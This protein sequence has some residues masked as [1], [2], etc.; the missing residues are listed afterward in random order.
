MSQDDLS[1]KGGTSSDLCADGDSW[2]K[3]GAVKV[4][5]INNKDVAL[6]PGQLEQKEQILINLLKGPPMP[7]KVVNLPEIPTASCN[8]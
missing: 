1:N 8:R 2:N 3:K 7:Y 4:K 5:R 6:L